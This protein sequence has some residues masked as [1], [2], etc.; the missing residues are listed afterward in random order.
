METANEGIWLID[1]NNKTTFVNKKLC[2]ILGYSE[3]EMMGREI[4][5]F[6]DEE[7]KEQAAEMMLQKKEGKS[8]QES[9]KYIAK[10]GKEVWAN[11]SVNPLFDEDN[12]YKG[13]L[14]MVTDITD[15]VILEKQLLDEKINKQKE[16]AKEK[17][18]TWDTCFVVTQGGDTLYGKVEG[19][20]D[21]TL[22]GGSRYE[23]KEAAP[24]GGFLAD[25]IKCVFSGEKSQRLIT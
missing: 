1:D 23:L 17:H 19:S 14:A 22:G 15:R 9:F 24:L 12:S 10:S 25:A 16:V 6:M 20:I 3:K 2:E 18:K 7:G 4:Y 5:D 8:G 11:L 21:Y 13:S